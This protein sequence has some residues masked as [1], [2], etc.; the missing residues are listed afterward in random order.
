MS[1]L[2]NELVEYVG[3]DDE[4]ELLPNLRDGVGVSPKLRDGVGVSPLLLVT[5]SVYRRSC[6]M[7]LCSRRNCMT[8]L[9]RCALAGASSI[10]HACGQ[11][12]SRSK[13]SSPINSPLT[14]DP[15]N[16]YFFEQN[17]QFCLI[18]LKKLKRIDRFICRGTDRK[19]AQCTNA[20]V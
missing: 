9:T 20:V 7:V 3:D 17:G 1:N 12:A 4:V 2:R 8:A 11:E 6:V 5:A 16:Y 10:A 19:P 13:S 14:T 18:L 15:R